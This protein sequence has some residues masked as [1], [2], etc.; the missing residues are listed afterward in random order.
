MVLF[1]NVATNAG[2]LE[3]LGKAGHFTLFAPTNDAFS[4]LG[5]EVMDRLMGNKGALQ[6]KLIIQ[7]WCALYYLEVLC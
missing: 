1:Q 5:E 4:K 7:F 6:G 2:L 3:K